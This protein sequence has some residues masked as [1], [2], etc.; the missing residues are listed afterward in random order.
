[1][2]H[3]HNLRFS[4]ILLAAA[5][6]LSAAPALADANIFIINVDGANE[7]FNDPTPAASVPAAI[8]GNN[9]GA[10]LGQ[11]RLIVFQAAADNWGATVD[12]NVDI[13]VTA[14]FNPLGA[15]VLGSAGTTFVF[16]DFPGAAFPATWYPSALTDKLVDF[17]A[18]PGF[19]DIN[20]QF[21][22][23]F[24]FYL[25]LDNNHG[26]LNDLLVVVLHELAHG[27]GF[28]NFVNEASG[29]NFLGFTDVYS[30]F[31]LDETTGLH[32]SAMTTNAERQASAIN[33][34]NVVW[35]GSIVTA[36]VPRVLS[37]GVPELFVNSPA[38][39]AG[40]YDLGPASFGAPLTAAGVTDDVVLVN[41]GVAPTTN[42]CEPLPAGSLAGVIG[43]ADRGVCTFVVK[44]K[45]MQDAGAVGAII[46]DN[47]AD[48]PPAGL[49]GVDPTIT[50]PSGR[51]TLATGNTLKA[52]LPGL[53][54]SLRLNNALRAGASENGFAQLW[55]VVPVA[56]GSSIS[57][58]DV[59]ASPNQLMEPAINPD[60]THSV[61]PPQDL[62]FPLL[63]D[64]GW[65][66]DADF[67][68]VP[69]DQD[70]C[71]G[72]DIGLTVVIDGC[73]SGVPNPIFENGCTIT[74]LVMEC[75]V[76]AGNHGAF[77]SCV[78]HTLNDLKKQGIISGSQKG[79]IQSC[80]A[81]ADIP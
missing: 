17:D 78:S 40:S 59:I 12:S 11:M 42:A 2:I 24:T 74:D 28:A 34:R 23:N 22:S 26:A 27:L 77:V 50:I 3:K 6:L 37:F 51:V 1:M 68:S 18:A 7:G 15:N 8:K 35:D 61:R 72:S 81:G 58:W 75:A 41:D 48:T 21:S 54:V 5:L 31:T 29:A 60:L 73:N 70:E 39:I 44:V 16:R 36:Q 4:A 65:F 13:F 64:I 46:A 43:L 56:L 30:Q 53:N 49:G 79:A 19:A 71:P 69:D 76:G 45:N 55:A 57:H 52:N 38:G 62:T 66:T 10:T 67:D 47:V 20:A 25:G 9:P 14:A 33:V 32:W 63:G 80:A